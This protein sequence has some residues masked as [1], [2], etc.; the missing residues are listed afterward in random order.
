[1]WII[2]WMSY[3]QINWKIER[4]I[5]WQK[6][7]VIYFCNLFEFTIFLS[8]E[9]FFLLVRFFLLYF[10]CFHG[11]SLSSVSFRFVT[12]CN[13]SCYYSPRMLFF[14]FF[15]FL[16]LFFFFFFSFI[17]LYTFYCFS[18]NFLDVCVPLEMPT[19]KCN[20]RLLK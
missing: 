13:G 14:F 15:F 2:M 4:K 9:L 12:V 10:L 8:F 5:K 3:M 6:Q 7:A 18:T 11:S 1:M 20:K 19:F 16:F 17:Y